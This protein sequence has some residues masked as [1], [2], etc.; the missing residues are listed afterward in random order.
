MVSWPLLFSSEPEDCY[1]F[2]PGPPDRSYGILLREGNSSICASMLAGQMHLTKHGVRSWSGRSLQVASLAPGLR[3]GNKEGVWRLPTWQ[4]NLCHASEVWRD[5]VLRMRWASWLVV[6]GFVSMK[7]TSAVFIMGQ[8]N[9]P[10]YTH[11][12]ILMHPLLHPVVLLHGADQFCERFNLAHVF[13]VFSLHVQMFKCI[14]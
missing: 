9:T 3:Q 5:G 8:L 10:L 14:I 12:Y 11:F 6:F 1:L 13:N 7:K 4:S 2:W